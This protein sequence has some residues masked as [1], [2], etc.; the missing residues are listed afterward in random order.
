MLRTNSPA[1]GPAQPLA[2]EH[3]GS[4]LVV[5][6]PSGAGKTSL[7]RALLAEDAG[8]RL[9]VSCTTRSPR[10]GEVPGVDYDFIDRDEF[11]RRRDA[12]DFIEWAEVHGNLY[13]T[14]R[15]W[16]EGQMAAGADV[17]LEIDW[18]GAMQVRRLLPQAVLAFVLPPSMAEL[19][20]R[21]EG[22]NQDSAETIALRIEAARHELAQAE[23]FEYVII[24]Q[25]FAVA[26]RE[27]AA[28]VAAA[29]CRFATQRARHRAIFD[30]LGVASGRA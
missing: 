18:Q 17:I 12:G 16:I 11:R 21:L 6:A 20:R 19:R 1:T 28:V 10:P 14:S 5:S 13:G 15:A 29:R 23:Q 26:L 30:E 8:I 27:L 22:R 9:S 24:N 3:S 25:D 4:L 7:V 2:V